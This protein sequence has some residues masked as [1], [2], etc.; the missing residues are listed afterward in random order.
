MHFICLFG[1]PADSAANRH[2]FEQRCPC[3]ATLR[4]WGDV[5]QRT[6]NKTAGPPTWEHPMEVRMAYQPKPRRSEVSRE[7]VGEPLVAGERT[8]RPVVRVSGRLFHLQA[9]TGGAAYGMLR[10]SPRSVL[11]RESDGSERRLDLFDLTGTAMRGMAIVAAL[12]P[13][14]YLLFRLFRRT[15]VQERTR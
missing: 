14:G 6:G 15:V 11:V 10:L 2:A 13:L 9:R 7:I 5:R 12:V 4:A 8:I 3:S 1:F